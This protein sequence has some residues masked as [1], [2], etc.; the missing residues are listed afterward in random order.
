M[1]Y[2]SKKVTSNGIKFDSKKEAERYAT[3]S[4]LQRA[5]LIQDLKMQECFELLPRQM[6]KVQVRLK[7]KVKTVERVDE[8]AVHYHADF[9]YYD[10]QKDR[11]IIEE[12]KSPMTAHIRDYPLRRKLVKL[13]VARL[14]QQAGREL[15][16]F[17]E[18]V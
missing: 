17:N 4:L 9:F 8:M 7:T 13:M 18:I 1:K 14:N 11:Y 10:T 12:I 6:K 16:E 2:Y 3:L 5:G 15:Y